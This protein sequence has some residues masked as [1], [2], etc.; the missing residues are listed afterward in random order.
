MKLIHIQEAK[1]TTR[2]ETLF[3][4]VEHTGDNEHSSLVGPFSSSDD[5]MAFSKHMFDTYGEDVALTHEIFASKTPEK[6]EQE[7]KDHRDWMIE[8]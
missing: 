6:Y 4:V 2:D 8:D 3:F 1:Y 7:I 5:A